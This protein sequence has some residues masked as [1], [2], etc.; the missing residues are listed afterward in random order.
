MPARTDHD[1]RRQRVARLAADLVADGGL[2]AATH[3][4]IAEAAGCSTTIVSHY[5]SGKRDLVTA[6][7]QEVGDRVAD[8]VEAAR[9]TEDPLAAIL[10]ALLPLDAD[11]T[12]DWRLL[13]TFLGLAATDAELTAEQ[14]ARAGAARAQ[15]EAALEDDKQAG[16]IPPGTDVAAAARHLLSLVLG[17]GMQALFDPAEW[18]PDRMRAAVADA[19]QQVRAPQAGKPLARRSSARSRQ[20]GRVVAGPGQDDQV[21]LEI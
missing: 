14:R 12:R 10:A 19:V 5:F 11:R 6:T 21:S 15:V 8:R 2:A 17:M 20:R 4:R 16:R 1:E 13:F 18:P 9:G 7:Y 3:R